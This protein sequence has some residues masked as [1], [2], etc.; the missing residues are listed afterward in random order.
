MS[1]LPAG[2]TQRGPTRDDFE[3]VMEL[4]STADITDFF[5]FRSYEPG[6]DDRAVLIMDVFPGGEPSSMRESSSGVVR[7]ISAKS[8]MMR[9]RCAG[10][11][12]FSWRMPISTLEDRNHITLF[13]GDERLL[14][15]RAAPGAAAAQ[16]TRPAF[17]HA[18]IDRPHVGHPRRGHHQ[19]HARI[20]HPE[21]RELPE[22]FGQIKSQ[23]DATDHRWPRVGEK[24]TVS[25]P[26]GDDA[27]VVMNSPMHRCASSRLANW[28]R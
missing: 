5:F 17:L 21:G 19:P 2:Y 1:E 12:G 23:A 8:E 4:T 26:F 11:V 22:L 18:D 20:A 7:V 27:A 3:A 25:R 10:D 6:K 28:C 24:A 15:R 16:A 13:Q 14:P 9:K